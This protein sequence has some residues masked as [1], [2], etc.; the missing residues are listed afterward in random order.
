[1]NALSY[2][3]R[4]ILLDTTFEDDYARHGDSEIALWFRNVSPLN[5]IQVE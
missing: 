2:T 1:M 5:E 3:I 4:E